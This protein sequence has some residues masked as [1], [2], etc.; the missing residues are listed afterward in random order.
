[1]KNLLNANIENIKLAASFI[2][3]GDLVA[4]PTETV[5]GLGANALN[6]YAVSKIFE[7]KQRPKFNPLI[8][9]LAEKRLIEDYAYIHS[10]KIQKL[11]DKFLPGPITFILRKKDI[12]PFIVTAGNMTVAVRVPD[13]MI[14]LSLLEES[15][16]PIAAP[17][18]N[19]FT[20]LSPTKAIHVFQQLGERVSV[21]L[22]GG[23]TEYGLE[24]TII[25]EDNGKVFILRPGGITREMLEETI[26]ENIEDAITKDMPE[27]PGMMKYH[28]SPNTRISFLSEELLSNINL[29][30]EE[31]GFLLFNRKLFSEKMKNV[32][33]LS[34]KSDLIEAAANLFKML[35]ELDELNLSQIFVEKV[36]ETGIGVAILDRLQKAVNRFL[37]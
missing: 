35:H 14:A 36:P 4:F 2:M 10:D 5:Y 19:L 3:N 12:I 16:V 33:I 7:I 23:E 18:A 26:N 20:K 27:A 15:G 25:K 30:N 32:K 9:H 34:S 29:E 13:N 24:S 37:L 17:S 1:M 6:E 31:F 22:D 28:Y 11:I 8:V 21:I